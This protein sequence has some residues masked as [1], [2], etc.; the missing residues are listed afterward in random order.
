M[1]HLVYTN[2]VQSAHLEDKEKTPVEREEKGGIE[3][4]NKWK[5]RKGKK[6]PQWPQLT[7]KLM[8]ASP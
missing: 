5:K 6:K 7:T 1:A 4:R 3:G 2:L 8:E